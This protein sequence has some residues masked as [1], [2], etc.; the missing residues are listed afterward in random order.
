MDTTLVQAGGLALQV[1]TGVSLAAAAGLR[2][3]LP[4]FVAGAAGRWDVIPLTDSFAWLESTPALIVFGV[5]VVTEILADKVPVVDNFLDGLQSFVK[6]VAGTIL[7]VAVVT[8]LAPLP[9]FALGLIAGG[10]TAGVVH[11][12]KAHARLGST[13]LTAGIANPLVSIGED[14]AALFGAAL[15]LIQPLIV[16]LLFLAAAALAWWFWLRRGRNGLE[17]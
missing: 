5:A 10:G 4:L 16:I 1:A 15:A 12:T 2:A 8:D 9:A 13:V 11:V 6:P 17:T 14:V 7:V 3:F